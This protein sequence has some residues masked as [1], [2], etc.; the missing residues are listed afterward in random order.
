MGSN[1]GWLNLKIHVLSFSYQT[2]VEGEKNNKCEDKWRR[3]EHTKERRGKQIGK[4]VE[5]GGTS[6]AASGNT[7]SVTQAT[8]H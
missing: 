7:Q 2:A 1:P 4:R 8:N 5:G 6:R 3:G